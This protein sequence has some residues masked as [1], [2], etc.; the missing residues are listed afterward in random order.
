M[1]SSKAIRLIL[2]LLALVALLA[3]WP[4]RSR[5]PAYASSAIR[6]LSGEKAVSL[7]DRLKQF[8]ATARERWKPYFERSGVAYPPARV[9]L[10]GLKDVNALEVYAAREDGQYL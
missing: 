1:K 2:L 6:Q 7:D 3:L 10:V 8:G 5:V 9:T 4:M